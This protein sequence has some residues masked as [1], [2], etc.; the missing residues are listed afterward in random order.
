MAHGDVDL[1]TANVP[2]SSV[3]FPG[4]HSFVLSHCRGRV[5]TVAKLDPR[6]AELVRELRSVLRERNIQLQQVD[7][8]KGWSKGYLSQVVNGH[9][10][11]KLAHLFDAL[12]V[13]GVEPRDFF[14]RLCGARPT[15]DVL[16]RLAAL[17]AKLEGA[18]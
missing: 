13:A 4:S 14:A 17:E 12:E 6:F 15:T 10:D 7:A 18:S 1:A 3:K 2:M 5:S 8:A 16:R 11:M 9:K